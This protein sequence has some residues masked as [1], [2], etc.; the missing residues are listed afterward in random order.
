M[1]FVEVERRDMEPAATE[2]PAVSSVQF[3]DFEELFDEEST[4]DEEPPAV[5]SPRSLA[6]R[7]EAFFAP[8]SRSPS[9]ARLPDVSDDAPRAELA[10]ISVEHEAG[11]PEV[12]DADFERL[13]VLGLGSFGKV[14]L[15]RHK[16]T[17]ALYAL[18]L[19]S[20]ARLVD[21]KQVERMLEE[22]RVLEGLEHPCV[23]R[24]HFAFRT[25]G[26]ACLGF[27]YC[28]GGELF[29]HLCRRR[30]L[31]PD[32]VAFYGA[33]IALA[34]QCAHEHGVV[35]RD[36]KPENCI[37]AGDAAAPDGRWAV[38]VADLGCARELR[39]AP[40]YTDYV[41]TRWRVRREGIFL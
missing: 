2:E 7:A 8:R 6:S 13:G 1:K 10:A 12:S 21:Q 22:K 25:P 31:E 3:D 24:L 20:L 36:V 11:R 26:H 39:S 4:T 15:A 9:P 27:E 18:K 17:R 23:V 29:H 32:A 16:T 38:K 40:P 37:V 30:R 19:V 35:Y 5:P 33:E 41:S 34:L 14:V 28:A